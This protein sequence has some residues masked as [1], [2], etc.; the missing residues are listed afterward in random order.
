MRSSLTLKGAN[1][2]I[3]NNL[4]FLNFLFNSV[5]KLATQDQLVTWQGCGQA[6]PH[7]RGERSLIQF[8]F[9]LSSESLLSPCEL[10]STLT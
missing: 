10:D 2:A 1:G 5:P 9:K 8:L 6:L 4:K 7:G 3:R